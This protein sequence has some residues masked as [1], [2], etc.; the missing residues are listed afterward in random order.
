MQNSANRSKALRVPE[1][2]EGTQ[3]I[4]RYMSFQ[5]FVS[6]LDKK[7]LW[8]S[9]ADTFDDRL[10]GRFSK[11]MR[12]LIEQAY[13]N[14]SMKCKL[15]VKTVDEFQE[16]FCKR[17]FI[18]CWH[19][20]FEENLVMWKL[21]G[22][23]NNSVVIQGTIQGMVD[24]I[25]YP[26][27]TERILK[28][29]SVSYLEQNEID[30]VGRYE[31]YFFI[32]RPHFSFEQEFRIAL[33]AYSDA[34]NPVEMPVGTYLQIDIDKLIDQV[35]VHPDS[36]DWFVDVVK[37]VSDKYHMKSPVSKGGYGEK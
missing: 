11:G 25:E 9:R 13:I 23:V 10:E 6:L 31:D 3:K 18:S 36:D 30:A 32:K 29:Q 17:T 19:K 7:S 8:L 1:G 5:K 15:E 26:L 27:V 28:L 22:S 2:I 20:N 12:K 35:L 37:S 24:S 21:Y 34:S 14:L 33:D 16:Q 4:W